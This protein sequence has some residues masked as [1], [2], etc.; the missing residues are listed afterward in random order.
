M[1]SFIH[2][3]HAVSGFFYHCHAKKLAR[4]Y[5]PQFSRISLNVSLSD[6]LLRKKPLQAEV[7]VLNPTCRTISVYELL[8]IVKV[9]TV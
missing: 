2:K 4:F 9:L 3:T 1:L 5:E 8:Q 7:I 6:S